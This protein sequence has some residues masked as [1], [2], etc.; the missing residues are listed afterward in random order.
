[1][2]DKIPENEKRARLIIIILH[3]LSLVKIAYYY[4]KKILAQVDFLIHKKM[5]S[6]LYYPYG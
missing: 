3:E 4:N 2:A 5:N 6:R 1:L